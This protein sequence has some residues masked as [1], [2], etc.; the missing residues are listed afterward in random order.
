VVTLNRQ[1]CEAL[2]GCLLLVRPVDAADDWVFETKYKQ[3]IGSRSIELVATK[4]LHATGMPDASVH[5]LRHTFTV[6]TLKQ[7]TSLR[8]SQQAL[9]ISQKVATL[10]LDL[11]RTRWTGSCRRT[12]YDQATP[13]SRQLGEYSVELRRQRI[14]S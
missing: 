1:A 10:Y 2:R 12:P 6:H 13:L 14:L 8:V 11:A 4:Y 7:G 9:G 5:T 3:R